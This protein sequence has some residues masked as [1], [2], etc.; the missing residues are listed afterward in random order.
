MSKTN[1]KAC[2][3]CGSKNIHLDPHICD[4]GHSL[5]TVSVYC[6]DCGLSHGGTS[7][8]EATTKWNRRV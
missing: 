6:S 3:C 1:L 8:E 5:E 2:P 4:C 7:Q